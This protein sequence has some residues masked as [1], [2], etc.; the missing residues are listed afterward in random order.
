MVG[1]KAVRTA[2]RHVS[3]LLKTKIMCR[4]AKHVLSDYTP[5]IHALVCVSLEFS[6]GWHTMDVMTTSAVNVF[7]GSG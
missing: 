7:A 6:E 2:T 1:N 5:K 4:S 3:H